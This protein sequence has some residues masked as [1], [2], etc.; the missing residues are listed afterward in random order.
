MAGKSC[1]KCGK[2]T[3]F[4]T[5]TG[6]KCTKC[7]YTVYLP[8]N[9][10]MGGLGKKCPICGKMTVFNNKCTKCGARGY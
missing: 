5:S 9:G 1:P 8:P 7:G 10:G 3:L 2:F 4:E 6:R